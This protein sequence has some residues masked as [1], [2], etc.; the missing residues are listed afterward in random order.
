M[1]QQFVSYTC[2]C[3]TLKSN[4]IL[5]HTK[6]PAAKLWSIAVSWKGENPISWLWR[7]NFSYLKNA[8]SVLSYFDYKYLM[9]KILAFHKI[10]A[11]MCISIWP[12][13]RVAVGKMKAYQMISA[14]NVNIYLLTDHIHQR[15]QPLPKIANFCKLFSLSHRLLVLAL[16]SQ[17]KKR[18]ESKVL[19]QIML[20]MH[21]KFCKNLNKF[22]MTELGINFLERLWIRGFFNIKVLS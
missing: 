1:L 4:T 21:Q 8:F 19:M 13:E 16:E 2:I 17:L 7:S 22:F 9:L 11:H 6:V 14:T 15:M 10:F 12:S 5:R 3:Y 20:E 18:S